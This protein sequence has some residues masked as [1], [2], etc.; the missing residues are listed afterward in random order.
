MNAHDQK[1]A[2]R[3]LGMRDRDQ[4]VL[5]LLWQLRVRYLLVLFI[6]G[7]S[8]WLAF[9]TRK[10]EFQ[11]LGMFAMGMAVGVFFR[12]IRWLR[13]LKH[14]WKFH[15]RVI[16]WSRVSALA[17]GRETRDELEQIPEE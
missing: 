2:A 6:L 7:C 1:A 3:L 5:A 4:S 17:E 13:T 16:D 14:N 8:G 12:D 11:P 9:Q 15:R 10:P